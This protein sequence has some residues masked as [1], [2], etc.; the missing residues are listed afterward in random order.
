MPKG[1]ASPE[2][3]PSGEEAYYQAE[4]ARANQGWTDR[5]KAN[6]ATTVETFTLESREEYVVQVSVQLC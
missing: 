4:L 5:G 1:G 2:S 6:V 3:V